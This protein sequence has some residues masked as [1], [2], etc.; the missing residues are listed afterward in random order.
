MAERM[1]ITSLLQRCPSLLTLD[2]IGCERSTIDRRV[3]TDL[4]LD[5]LL[6]EGEIAILS[7]PSNACEIAAR[8][9]IFSALDD[10]AFADRMASLHRTFTALT[11]AL[12]SYKTAQTEL[13]RLFLFVGLAEKAAAA[14]SVEPIDTPSGLAVSFN[15]YI[16]SHEVTEFAAKLRAEA[17]A[18]RKLCGEISQFAPSFDSKGGTMKSELPENSLHDTLRTYGER[19]GLI[20]SGRIHQSAANEQRLTTELSDAISRLYPDS[21]GKLLQFELRWEEL[22]NDIL[23]LRRGEIAFYTSIHELVGK[24]Q[25]L[26]MPLCYPKI[27]DTPKYTAADACDLSLILKKTA[28]VGNDIE[29]TSDERVFFLTGANGGGKTTYL[30]SAAVNL[31]LFSGGAPICARSA[32]IWPFSGLFTHFPSDERFAG[33]GRLVDE[34]QRMDMIISQCKALGDGGAFVLLNESFSGTDDRKG[35]SL[36]LDTVRALA[37]HGCFVLYVTHFHEVADSG[38]PVLTTVIDE[39]DDNR[40]TFRITRVGASRSSFA[41]DILKKYRLDRASLEERSK[42]KEG[43]EI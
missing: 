39:S 25:R 43:G 17:A 26:G 41:R 20:T 21:T 9:A 5:R 29:F 35:L 23:H 12:D 36:T 42:Q 15:N 30:R 18:A 11:Q 22:A 7:R 4:N 37:E 33:S 10:E 27:A 3:F 8:Q 40:R 19:L 28:A 1:R 14:Y 38:Y 6:S 31:L 2:E 34:K 24:A 32:E 16:S 13:E